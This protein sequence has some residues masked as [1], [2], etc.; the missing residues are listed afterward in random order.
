MNRSVFSNF[1]AIFVGRLISSLSMWIAL[2]ILA[3]L[4][5]PA[6]VGV[7]VLAQAICIP[8]AEIAK[9]GLRDV[10][11]SVERRMFNF[12]TYV[13]L[14][15]ISVGATFICIALVAGLLG[16]SAMVS[17]VIIIYGATRCVEMLSDLVYSNFQLSERMEYIGRSLCA[18]GP[19]SLILFAFGFW[20]TGSLVVAASG[21]LLAYS[22]VFLLYDLPKGN[23]ISAFDSADGMHPVWSRADIF[24]LARTA[25]PLTFATLL[26]VVAQFVPRYAVEGFLG[27]A[28][29]GIFAALLA[30]AMAPDRLVKSL[31][32]AV[33]VRLASMFVNGQLREFILLL[34]KIS[35]IVIVGSAI[36]TFVCVFAGESILTA[37]Y[38]EDYA[39]QNQVFV[40]LIV[41]ASF[42]LVAN[43]LRLGLVAARSYW[44]TSVQS[45][46]A[47]IVAVS[48]SLTL[49]P[50]Y[51]LVGASVTILLIF[52]AQ[53]VFSFFGVVATVRAAE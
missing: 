4:S 43:I 18:V 24:R 31:G 30:F 41:A 47:A 20:S 3:K 15:L 37:I 46:A 44:W 17:S 52:F 16:Q 9:M 32:V 21:Q 36:L 2:V 23:Q 45:G 7:F 13:G 42:R 14:R 40:I 6:T 28:T 29:L 35:L 50:Q 26:I 51:G 49:I 10:R 48:G 8:I 22:V 33:S 11:V 5:D 25:V 39:R 27:R 1:S 53:L 19:L 12:G 34:A 38:T